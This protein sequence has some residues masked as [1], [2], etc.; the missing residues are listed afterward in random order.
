MSSF[1]WDDNKNQENVEKHQVDFFEAQKAFLDSNR[2]IF[3]DLVHS[4]SEDRFFCVGKVEKGI[5]TVRF[6]YR[7][8]KIRIIGAG[9]WR[10]GKKLYENRNI[11]R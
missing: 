5:L 3:R 11:Q 1:E 4:E 6:T 9:Y 7:N 8:T 10:K 2:L